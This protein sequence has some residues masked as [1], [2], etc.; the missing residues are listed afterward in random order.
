MVHV[1]ECFQGIGAFIVSRNLGYDLVQ[2]FVALLSS[3]FLQCIHRRALGRLVG[4]SF[5]DLLQVF[6]KFVVRRLTQS[7]FCN[8][9]CGPGTNTSPSQAYHDATYGPTFTHG[10]FVNGLQGLCDFGW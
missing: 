10:K 4:R 8:I 7:S 9:Q 1:S 6:F 5:T 3:K 2:H